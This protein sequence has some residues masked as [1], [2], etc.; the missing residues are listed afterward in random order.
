MVHY[1][2][3]ANK[4]HTNR[5]KFTMFIDS[6]KGSIILCDVIPAQ[7]YRFSTIPSPK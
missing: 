2:T 1:I 4:G 6:V 3:T 7:H 5:D